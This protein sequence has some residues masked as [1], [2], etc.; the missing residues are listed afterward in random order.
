MH[1]VESEVQENFFE[2]SLTGQQ[3]STF[4]RK[5]NMELQFA[6]NLNIDKLNHNHNHNHGYHNSYHHQ[7]SQF[8]TPALISDQMY[9]CQGGTNLIPSGSMIDASQ[10]VH[11]QDVF[12]DQSL[13]PPWYPEAELFQQLGSLA[14]PPIPIENENEANNYLSSTC[15][16]IGELDSMLFSNDFGNISLQPDFPS[17]QQMDQYLPDLIEFGPFTDI[18]L[19]SPLSLHSS[20]SPPQDYFSLFHTN[21]AES[22]TERV[23]AKTRI[24]VHMYQKFSPH[25]PSQ[26]TFDTGLLPMTRR[27][28]L[29]LQ[30]QLKSVSGPGPGPGPGPVSGPEPEPEPEPDRNRVLENSGFNK[31]FNY[32]QRYPGQFKKSYICLTCKR[33]LCSAYSLSRHQTTHHSNAQKK[34]MCHLCSKAFSNKANLRRHI[35]LC[36]SKTVSL[37]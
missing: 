37:P 23:D 16:E 35:R 17:S 8:P 21:Q 36:H 12:R 5:H 1:P 3:P 9:Y 26:P 18:G 20:Q 22:R 31:M 6:S 27:A 33:S 14:Q 7:Y 29:E 11:S 28:E 30:G 4:P 15:T 13:Y 32:K 19:P 25:Q 2:Y 34:D 24:E 10:Y